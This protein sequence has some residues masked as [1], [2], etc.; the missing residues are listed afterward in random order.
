MAMVGPENAM[1]WG[2]WKLRGGWWKTVP[3]LLGYMG[4]V[5]VAIAATVQFNPKYRG[6]VLVGWTTGLMGLEAAWVILL[7]CGRVT[8]AIRQDVVS[9]MME[10][11]R[12]MPMPA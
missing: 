8:T 2:Q 4:I 7:G 9:R 3:L 10:S 11:H 6:Q 1:A 5:A 12:M